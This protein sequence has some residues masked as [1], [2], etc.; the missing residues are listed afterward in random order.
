MAVIR[1][2][3]PSAREVEHVEWSEVRV[4]DELWYTGIVPMG[5]VRKVI[6]DQWGHVR[7]WFVDA[8][9]TGRRA[10]DKVLRRLRKEEEL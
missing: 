6:I 2:T 5:T 7:V 10:S 8:P 4:G 9:V 1:Y 3:I